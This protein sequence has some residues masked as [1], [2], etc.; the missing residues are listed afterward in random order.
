M[1]EVAGSSRVWL[2]APFDR[3]R[4]VWQAFLIGVSVPV[5]G[6]SELSPRRGRWSWARPPMFTRRSLLR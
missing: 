5:A 3:C 6:S 2:L 4:R 1:T